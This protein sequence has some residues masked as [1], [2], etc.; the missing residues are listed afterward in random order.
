MLPSWMA[1]RI[2]FA[3]WNLA[4]LGL[5]VCWSFH[6]RIVSGDCAQR[7]LMAASVAAISGICTTLRNGQFGIVV[8]AFVLVAMLLEEHNKHAAAGLLLGA[9]MLKPT[10]AIPFIIPF[11]VRRRLSTLV[12]FGAYLAVGT[13][14]IWSM[15]GAGRLA[16][17][18][19]M[20]YAW[21]LAGMG[22]YGPVDM[23]KSAGVPAGLANGLP[24]AIGAAAALGISLSRWRLPML[25][26]FGVLSAVAR[27][28]AYH[29]HYDNII[30]VFL[31]VA[32]ADTAL[33][34]KDYLSK[35]IF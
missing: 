18:R 7:W 15:T 6:L 31:L 1:T 28:W 13:V 2:W 23:L 8:A 27:L 4:A 29:K 12:T 34:C 20:Q 22:G 32:L 30:L 21:H 5:L 9:A 19:D 26:L 11:L 24:A 16:M 35:A 33:K 17:W 3:T 14:A 10:L 25:P